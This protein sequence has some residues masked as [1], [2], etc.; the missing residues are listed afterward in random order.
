MPR[1]IESAPPQQAHDGV[2]KANHA[3]ELPSHTLPDFPAPNGGLEFVATGA[4]EG[5]PAPQAL[6]HLPGPFEPPTLPDVSLP[7]HAVAEID[8][9]MA[10]LPDFIFDLG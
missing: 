7:D 4:P 5:H 1:P 9:P 8:P 10:H 6:D 3:V 2:A